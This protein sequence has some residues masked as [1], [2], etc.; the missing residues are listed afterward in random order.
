MACPRTRSSRGNST[1]FWPRSK[2]MRVGRRHAPILVFLLAVLG[3]A[4]KDS[5]SLVKE[6]PLFAAV[7]PPP[8]KALVYVF[9]PREEQ[10]RW[11]NL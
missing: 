11:G 2:V 6:G 8:G 5:S 4:C 10:G 1:T 3:Y 7:D 9:W